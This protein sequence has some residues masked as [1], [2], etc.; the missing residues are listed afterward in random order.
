MLDVARHQHAHEVAR[1]L[2]AF[3]AGDDDFV[4]VLGVEIAD[5]ALDQRAFLIDQHG[6]HG[7][8]RQVAHGLP[9][10]QQVF[11]VALDFR[12]GTA[13]AG[14]AQD[15]AHAFRHFQFLGDL[16]ETAAV[17]GRG[18]LARN[19]AAAR[20]VGHKHR[21]AA[22]EREVG[23]E[24]R[25][26]GAA[27]FLDDLHQHDLPALDHLLNLVVATKARRALLHFLERVGA[28]DG[29]DGFFLVL[30]AIA[31]MAVAVVAIRLAGGRGVTGFF[32]VLAVIV[33]VVFVF[34]FVKLVVFVVVRVVF[35]GLMF[36]M[37]LF[38]FM[39]LVRRGLDG[40]CFRLGW[41][42]RRFH[43]AVPFGREVGLVHGFFRAQR[44]GL[45]RSL[46]ELGRGRFDHGRRLTAQRLA[47]KGVVTGRHRGGILRRL[48]GGHRLAALDVAPASGAAAAMA[49]A[50]ARAV[51]GFI[52]G[53][54]LG[55]RF[56]GEQCLP[57][58][59]RDLIVVRVDFGEGQEAVAVAAV[60]DE[61]RLQ[62]RFDP[63]DLG[64][65]DVTAKLLAVGAFEVEFLDP[66]ATQ[67]DHPG[68]FRVGRVDEHFVG[69]S[70]YSRGHDSERARAYLT[71]QDDADGSR[72]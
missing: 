37:G 64:E 47:I 19:A 60:I 40:S 21:I 42:E 4:D 56:L 32:L 23:G 3:L 45:R 39:G 14:G 62:R 18:D 38:G 31:I 49:A 57:V 24:C 11:E 12:L 1:F 10:P 69:H 71:A 59:D 17:L 61:G 44:G 43:G 2:V 8:Q 55:A 26:L 20:G 30:F 66:V 7:F 25:A 52:I 27:L 50:P 65:I 67:N 70:N 72:P 54:A 33:L 9:Q 29:L 53:V 6:G 41:R 58:G 34:F 13:G 5:R 48:F 46:G 63:G 15:D 16:L 68:F 36:F 35:A 51:V 22:G 28:A